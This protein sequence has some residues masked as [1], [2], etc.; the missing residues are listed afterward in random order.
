MAEELVRFELGDGAA[1]V[2][3]ELA[4][5]DSGVERVRRRA[6]G[7]RTEAVAGFEAGLDQI[8]DVAGRTLERITSMA[9]SPSTVELEFGVKFNVEAGAVI[10]RTGVEGHLKVKVVWENDALARRPQP[11]EEDA[12]PPAA[13][14]PE[15]APPPLSTPADPST[16][17]TPD[18]A[19]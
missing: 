12:P 4:E 11:E 16:S 17:P 15:P 14:E 13:P 3:V 2:Y 8:R 9:R 10:A 6:D 18:Q 5:D 19:H 7:T 1:A